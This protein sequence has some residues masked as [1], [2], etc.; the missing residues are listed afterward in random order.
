MRN[1]VRYRG[2]ISAI[3][4]APLTVGQGYSSTLIGPELGFGQVMGYHFDEPVIVLKASLGGQDLGYDFL[5]PGSP[6]Y[7]VSGTTYAGYLDTAR[8]WASATTPPA[9]H[10]PGTTSGYLG[11]PSGGLNNYAGKMFDDCV[12]SINAILN[13]FATEY[14]QYAAQGYQIAGI[15]W[16]QGWNDSVT[17]TFPE[18]YETNMVNF[19]KAYRSALNAPD[20]PFVIASCA[21]DGWNAAGGQLTVINAQLAAADPAKHPEFAGNVKTMD[22]RGYWRAAAVSPANQ[23]YHY[24]HNAETYMLV[25]DAMGRAMIDLL[26]T[27]S[28]NSYTNWIATYPAVG[29]LTGF[30]DDA[31]GDGI[32]NGVENFFGTDPGKTSG[33]LVA[34]AK[35]GNT[36]TFTHPQNATP[37]DG[38]SAVYR[39]SKDLVTF[40]ADGASDGG[41]TQVS[42]HAVVNGG[43]A[44]VTATVNGPADKLFVD[45][46]VTLSP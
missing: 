20:A 29:S 23:G 24:N 26:G 39:W 36:F 35:S 18:H 40:H 21:F 30:T 2:V 34:G 15:G 45:I 1:D 38:V 43:I 8:T 13:N 41:G 46:Q 10:V 28:S 44:T 6:R 32:P 7:T 16:F 22:C 9:Q 14:P 25:G 4:N 27:T 37:A 5:P 17:T 31:D 33:G 19:I 11:N 3:G 42:F 12:A